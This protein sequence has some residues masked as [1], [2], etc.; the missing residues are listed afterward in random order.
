[1]N[2]QWKTGLPFYSEWFL[3]YAEWDL[4]FSKTRRRDAKNGRRGARVYLGTFIRRYI[5]IYIYI[6]SIAIPSDVAPICGHYTRAYV[7]TRIYGIS[8]R[9]RKS[10][11]RNRDTKASSVKLSREFARCVTSTHVRPYGVLCRDT[12]DIV[13]FLLEGRIRCE[14]WIDR[15]EEMV[16]TF[17]TWPFRA[18]LSSLHP[19]QVEYHRY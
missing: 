1:M 18:R 3:R 19:T 16:L 14:R 10:L 12:R 7:L 17:A 5:Y 4:L 8:S 9:E 6:Y 15:K 2:I 11:A 13:H